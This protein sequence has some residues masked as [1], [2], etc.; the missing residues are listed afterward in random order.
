M[1]SD[2]LA[3]KCILDGD[4][5]K[6]TGLVNKFYP[7]IVM[8][9][10]K[11]GIQKED[12]ED[13][14]QEVMI[15]VYNNLY[16]YNEKWSFST[17]VFRIA[18]NAYKDFKKQKRVYTT[19]IDDSPSPPDSFSFEEHTER[20]HLK[21]IVKQMLGILDDDIKT[22]MILHYF[23]ELSLKEIGE[24]YN[25][26][27]EAV[28]MKLYRARGRLYKKFEKEMMGGEYCEVQL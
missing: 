23:H 21:N 14:A 28:K 27:P 22:I 2:R 12:A 15:K 7:R 6:F 5:E 19:P 9:I 20:M 11:M 17:W 16:R 3:V 26:S 25:L 18:I 13:I 1:D 24:I 8:Y 4:V 10:W